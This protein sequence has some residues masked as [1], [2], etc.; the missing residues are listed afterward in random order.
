[1]R[2]FG[3]EGSDFLGFVETFDRAIKKHMDIDSLIGI[4]I[5]AARVMDLGV[6]M[7]AE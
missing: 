1:V 3:I 4:G 6:V 2:C 7:L 5:H